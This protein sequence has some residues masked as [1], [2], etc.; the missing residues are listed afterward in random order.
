MTAKYSFRLQS[1][2][3][4]RVLPDKLIIGQ[5]ETETT[6]HVLLTLLAWLL[7]HRERLQI[8][9]NLH[10]DNIPFVPDVVQLDYALQPKLWI[11]CGDCG[12][13]KLNKLAVK[14]PDAEI[15]IMKPSLADAEQ[16]HRAMQKEDL[17][18][19]RYGLIAFDAAMFEELRGLL[20][21]RNDLLW[22]S[23]ELDE[24]NLQFDFNG[25][26]FDAPFTVLKF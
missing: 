20:R 21:P 13:N 25:L 12:V 10:H 26:W 7:F 19:D 14:M 23:G 4:R 16:L 15:W 5:S 2:D 24:P 1:Q 9:F 3:R 22:V 8:G 17:R 18:R 6:T 11:E